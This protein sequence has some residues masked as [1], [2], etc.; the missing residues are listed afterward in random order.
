MKRKWPQLFACILSVLIL[1][2]IESCGPQQEEQQVTQA[3][4]TQPESTPVQEEPETQP[5]EATPAEQPTV[6]ENEILVPLPN[7]AE[8]AV[9]IILVEIPAGKFQ[10][11]SP[12]TEEFHEENESPV[13]TVTLTNDYYIGKYEVTQA[14][15]LALMEE[16]PSTQ[17]GD[18]LPVNRVS[19]HEAQA[20]IQK[21][22]EQ[23]DEIRFRLPTEAEW[24][25]ACRA[26]T[27]TAT[28]IGE[29]ITEEQ[30]EE[31]AWFR[32]NSEANLHPVG[33]LK[34]NPWGLYDMHGNVW[35]WCSDW[36][37]T[38]PEQD[39]TDPKGPETGKEKVFRGASW[40]G[41]YKFMR[42]ADRG[43]FPPE[44]KQHTG[45]FRLAGSKTE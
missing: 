4:T 1:C 33:Q 18:N 28:Y 36:Y 22:N 12:P 6:K 31:Y 11:G 34:P 44:R 42:S 3:P 5:Q 38:Y 21:L 43:K 20:Y 7:L 41:E 9:P 10:M 37:G 23:Q 19:W 29:N 39:V 13:H 14:Q 2:I 25:Y 17:K 15:W 8:G 32:N 26:G 16:N 35:E 40:M 24:E 30:M 27:T 45:G